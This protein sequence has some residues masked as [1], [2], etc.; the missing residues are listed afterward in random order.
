MPESCSSLQFQILNSSIFAVRTCLFD[1]IEN[2]IWNM[3]LCQ[4]RMSDETLNPK[5]FLIIEIYS[6]SM[7]MNTSLLRRRRAHY[8]DI[9]FAQNI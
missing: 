5:N 7:L 6:Y 1:M 2:K 8:V 3:D 4:S 9:S